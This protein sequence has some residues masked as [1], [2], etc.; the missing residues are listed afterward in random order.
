MVLTDDGDS[1]TT[2][3]TL[4]HCN[5]Q[6][7]IYSADRVSVYVHVLTFEK[8]LQGWCYDGTVV[9]TTVNWG[10]KLWQHNQWCGA[11]AP[12]SAHGPDPNGRWINGHDTW[13]HGVY[14]GYLGHIV[15]NGSCAAFNG[16]I[17][18]AVVRVNGA[19]ASDCYNDYGYGG[20]VP[21]QD[22]KKVP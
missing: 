21:P 14:S 15:V 13:A 16:T 2:G 1:A 8:T 5:N 10:H 18:A 4:G 6:A 3:G 19:G 22:C 11:G 9:T 12:H 7:Y 17:H 20:Q